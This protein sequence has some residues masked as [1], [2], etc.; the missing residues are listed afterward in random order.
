[1]E[2]PTIQLDLKERQTFR[3]KDKRKSTLGSLNDGEQCLGF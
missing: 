3:S 1:M 2:D